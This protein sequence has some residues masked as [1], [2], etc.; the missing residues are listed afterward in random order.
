MS[1][2]LFREI[3]RFVRLAIPTGLILSARRQPAAPGRRLA[4]IALLVTYWSGIYAL[5]RKGGI[6]RTAEEWHLL[7]TATP[8]AFERHYN[9]CV[10]TVAE[11]L[12]LWGEYHAYRHTMRYDLVGSTVREHLPPGGRVL[13]IGCGAALVADRL[14]DLHATYVGAEYGGHQLDYA[15]RTAKSREGRPLRSFFVQADAE[16]LPF[17]DASFDVVVMTEVIEHL[18][19]PELAVWELARVLR[20]GGVF[21]M[22]TNNASEMPLRS[23]L[24]HM[25]AW[26]EKAIGF[27][28]DGLISHRP[29]IW[30]QPVAKALVPEG[31]RDVYIPHTW[32]K[33]A[34]TRRMFAAAGLETFHAGSFEF[35]P[36]QSQ[37]SRWLSKRGRWG[38][39]VVDVIEAVCSRLPLVNRLGCHVFMVA[40]RVP[41]G[42]SS[43]PPG[44]WPGPFSVGAGTEREGRV[45]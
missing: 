9:Q 23:P 41:G 35:P 37:T 31:D 3:R 2:R 42:T 45:P 10:P 40:R 22:T 7:Q 27:H 32:H 5:Y 43:P 15:V 38:E 25:F 30:P 20:P 4:L 8:E 1:S 6:Q 13:D 44:I 28:H 14:I 21:V 24:S 33:Q 12:A 17:A 39:N 34:E 11:E 29:W 19:R 16:H 26:L 36:P 18:L